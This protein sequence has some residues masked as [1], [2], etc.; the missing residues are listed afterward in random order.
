MRG[1]NGLSNV[2]FCTPSFF[3]DG[4]YFPLDDPRDP[5][6]TLLN[7]ARG[8]QLK[9]IEVYTSAGSIPPRFDRSSFT[10]CGSVVMWSK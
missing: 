8:D 2:R 6:G 3:L 1:G 4:M 9:G 10:G 5:L 7:F